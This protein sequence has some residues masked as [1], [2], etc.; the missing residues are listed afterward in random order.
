MANE[1]RGGAPACRVLE[2]LERRERVSAVV[3]GGEAERREINDSMAAS[4]GV[5]RGSLLRVEWYVRMMSKLEAVEEDHG[6]FS[7]GGVGAWA[8]GRDC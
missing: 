7:G 8:G 4:G 6:G 3:E 2:A 1:A 5:R